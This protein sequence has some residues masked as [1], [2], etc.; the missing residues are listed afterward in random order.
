MVRG[1]EVRSAAYRRRVRELLDERPFDQIVCYFLVAAVNLPSLRTATSADAGV[2]SQDTAALRRSSP[3]LKRT[4]TRSLASMPTRHRH[5]R[6]ADG[7]GH[8]VLQS[9]RK[10]GFRCKGRHGRFTRE[11]TRESPRSAA[12]GK[13]VSLKMYDLT[14][15]WNGSSGPTAVSAGYRHRPVQDS[16]S[17]TDLLHPRVSARMRFIAAS[18]RNIGTRTAVSGQ[19]PRAITITWGRRSSGL[20]PASIQG[21]SSDIFRGCGPWQIARRGSASRGSPPPRCDQGHA[22]SD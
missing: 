9:V 13:G 16:A 8:R 7:C 15:R 22:A 20:T 14:P 4:G 2:R 10:L 1:R 6:R 11:P 17:G 19:W 12:L 5:P 3:V 21:R 18:A